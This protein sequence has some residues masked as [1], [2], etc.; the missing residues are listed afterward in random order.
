[1]GGFDN[2]ELPFVYVGGWGPGL[3]GAVDAGFQYS[4]VYGN[5]QPFVAVELSREQRAKG[6]AHHHTFAGDPR[7]D[8][9]ATAHLF[10]F[11]LDNLIGFRPGRSG[12]DGTVEWLSPVVV[13]MAS[14]FGW[15]RAGRGLTFKRMTSIGQ[16]TAATSSSRRSFITGVAWSETTLGM[17]DPQTRAVSEMREWTPA[18]TK[19]CNCAGNGATGGGAGE[20]SNRRRPGYVV[21]SVRRADGMDVDSVVA[22]AAPDN[23]A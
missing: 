4:K 10:F 21:G 5:W 8:G 7:F 20:G 12:D 1:M 15:N 9:G 11:T 13:A 18:F 19:V 6:V 16:R 22:Q 17:Y 2:D 14:R 23:H 3:R